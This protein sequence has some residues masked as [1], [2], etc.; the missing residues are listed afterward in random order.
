MTKK[1]LCAL[2]AAATFP[3][4][5][6]A[7]TVTLADVFD[8]APIAGASVISSNGLI[9]GVTDKDGRIDAAEKDFPLSIRNLGYEALTVPSW[10][11]DTLFMTAVTYSLPEIVVSAAARPVTRVLTYAREY[12]TGATTADTMQLFSEYML[13]Y[14]FAEG[15][16]KGYS[17]S[18]K[19]AHT[20]AVRRYGRIARNDGRD[21]VMRPT[22]DDEIAVLSFIEPMVFMPY[23]TKEL[24]EAMKN[25][26]PAD[27]IPGKYYPKTICRLNKDL[28]TLDCDALAD[29]ENHAFEPWFF[30]MLGLTMEM[31]KASWALAYKRNE[32]GKYDLRDFIS[33]S[34]SL[35]VLGKGRLIKKIIGVKD[36][37]AINCYIE[38]YPVEIERLTP[39]E[40]KELTKTR[41]DRSETFREPAAV[42]PLPPSLQAMIERIDREVP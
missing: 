40:Y 13:E 11:T 17:K 41:R 8:R 21:S 12:C 10:S 22:A 1:L 6:P 20:L 37:I 16:V 29:Y 7:Q 39:Q 25:G 3:A 24:T 5:A 9:I 34:Y 28:F 27:T 30:K 26:A 18:D 15:K 36:T 35:H 38:Q 19:S 23:D 42:Q 32:S 4:A 31:R 14:F 2:L 33:G